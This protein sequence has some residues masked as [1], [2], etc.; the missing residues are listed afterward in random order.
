MKFIYGIVCLKCIR[1]CQD[2]SRYKIVS[3]HCIVIKFNILC[4]KTQPSSERGRFQIYYVIV[5][6]ILL[7][8]DHPLKIGKQEFT[9]Q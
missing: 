3:F 6:Y 8:Y 1:A 7:Y 9:S 5:Y 2:T 4:C